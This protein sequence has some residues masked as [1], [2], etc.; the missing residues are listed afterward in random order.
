MGRVIAVGLL[1][2]LS[3]CT[4]LATVAAIPGVVVDG[5]VDMFQGQERSLPVDMRTALV[6][7]QQG[8]RETRL[9]V[10][11]LEPVKGGYAVGF[12]NE[13]L[14]G[15]LRLTPQTPMLTTMNIKV[16]HGISREGSVEKT[17][18]DEIQNAS[19]HVT[20][21]QHFDFK[22]YGEI[23]AEPDKASKRLGWYRLQ[24]KLEIGAS[25]QK[26]WLTIKMPNGDKGFLEGA[27]PS[28]ASN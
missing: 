5:V 21:R 22:G 20:K 16:R 23:R 2:A 26:G 25:R 8:L 12:G 18:M 4:A 19:T 15:T 9:D 24:A 6:A 27:L 10:D 13:K 28:S 1:V 7:V 17:L 3:G 11:V 14:D